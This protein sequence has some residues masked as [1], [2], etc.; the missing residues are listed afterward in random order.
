MLDDS[1]VIKKYSET[2][3]EKSLEH[4]KD[5]ENIKV[6]PLIHKADGMRVRESVKCSHDYFKS[7][8]IETSKC[9]VFNEELVYTFVGRPAYKETIFPVCFVLEPD[10]SLLENVF[11]FDTGAYFEKR[12]SQIVENDIDINNYRIPANI[13]TIKKIISLFDGNNMKYYISIGTNIEKM[14]D[15][16]ILDSE[17]LFSYAL[18]NS[19]R[20]FCDLQFDTRCRTIE[21]VARNPIELSKYLKA[22]VIS[23]DQSRTKEF[24]DFISMIN[25]P[26]DILRYSTFDINAGSESNQRVKKIL[27]KYYIK[28]GLI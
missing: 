10:E 28:K 14:M 13:E 8:K 27:Y 26:V 25:R 17:E 18:L 16:D 2:S 22:I 20:K 7:G 21:N 23:T 1:Y 4:A 19:I 5:Y 6:L 11:V 3:F 9:D 24:N 12:Y 15:I